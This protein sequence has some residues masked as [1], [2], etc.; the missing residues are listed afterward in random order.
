MVVERVHAAE[1]IR[2]LAP[3]APGGSW[4]DAIV[5]LLERQDDLARI[6][7]LAAELGQRGSFEEPVVFHRSAD[8]T[9]R[10]AAGMHLVVAALHVG[11]CV[12]LVEAA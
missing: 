2:L 12:D 3:A 7:A 10:V 9:Y 4:D 6:E 8:G 11:G 5:E 1:V